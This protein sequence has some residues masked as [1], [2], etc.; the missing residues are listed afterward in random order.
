MRRA[1]K[2][3]SRACLPGL[4]FILSAWAAGCAPTLAAPTESQSALVIGR[5]FVNYA[6]ADNIWRFPAGAVAEGI[7]VE[8]EKRGTR[9]LINALTEEDGYFFLPNIAPGVYDV[10][11]VSITTVV[12]GASGNYGVSVQQFAIPAGTLVF[13][14]APGK[15]GYV[16]TV[17]VDVD[18][19]GFT[20]VREASDDTAATAYFSRKWAKSPWAAREMIPLRAKPAASQGPRL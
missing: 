7:L 20:S 15:V 14:P 9:D 3:F 16:G 13:S 12:P 17:V 2:I 1:R 4:V 11:R 8:M 10:R 5:V 18:D 19:R 6:R